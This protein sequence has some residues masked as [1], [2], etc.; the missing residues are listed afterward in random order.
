MADLH[1]DHPDPLTRSIT[2][3]ASSSASSAVGERDREPPA[4]TETDAVV[5]LFDRELDAYE[6]ALALLARHPVLDG[7]NTLARSYAGPRAHDVERG[8]SA[9]DAD[10]PRIK[11]GGVGAQFWAL[12]PAA[13]SDDDG[14]VT[15]T[16]RQLDAIR[17]L[18]DDCPDELRLALSAGD[19][20][21]ARNRGRIGSL[22]GPVS[23]PA[24]GDSLGTLRAYHALGVRAAGL[25][26]AGWTRGED[27]LSAF[28]QD[29]VREMNRLGVLVDLAGCGA[30]TA[31]RV[32]AVTRAPVL[33][34]HS[35]ARAL[36]DHPANV[37]D[38]VLALLPPNGG[39]CLVGFAPD[40]VARGGAAATVRDVAD[41]LDHVREVAGPEAVGL[42][43]MFGRE[44]SLPCT[45]GL[46]D[47]SC[48]PELIA[49]LFH[50]DWSEPDLAALTWG[51]AARV[52]RE[53]EFVARAERNR[54]RQ[55]AQRQK[56][57]PA[58]SA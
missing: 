47:A 39:V 41:H 2:T 5:D 48:Y 57:W 19:L 53:T 17:A 24:L 36:T 6:R 10:L 1:D 43:G 54:D 42:S 31:R 21:E 20:A 11:A 33:F 8:E 13:G 35:G 12:H 52:I 9:L 45:Q 44:A 51:N 7:F 40:Q 14:A 50:R 22:L 49:E 37:P 16:L 28:G 58:G 29:V 56:G 25:A 26:G 18:I 55:Q 15:E 3:S 27:G 30:D 46:E 38:E 23:G 4:A 34:T 32:L